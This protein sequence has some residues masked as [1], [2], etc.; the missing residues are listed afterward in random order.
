MGDEHQLQSP[1]YPLLTSNTK[2]V[3]AYTHKK[4]AS[5][6]AEHTTHPCL[7]DLRVSEA[8]YAPHFPI[9]LPPTAGCQIKHDACLS[10][11]P[12]LRDAHGSWEV[13]QRANPDV[14]GAT[15]QS[16][17]RLTFDPTVDCK[18]CGPRMPLIDVL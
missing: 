6:L 11:R 12:D 14:P 1:L 10:A 2:S 7:D 16:T 13:E 3:Y 4:P 8:G 5:S 9:A 18:P 17:E 15:V